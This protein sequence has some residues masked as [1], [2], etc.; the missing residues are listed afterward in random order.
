MF[1]TSFSSLR[2]LSSPGGTPSSLI[3]AEQPSC[4]STCLHQL[5][6][7]WRVPSSSIFLWYADIILSVFFLRANNGRQHAVN[8]E[9]YMTYLRHQSRVDS[10]PDGGAST[11]S[12]R[13]SRSS[14][15]H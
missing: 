6:L 15:L 9:K 14:T 5:S 3:S 13:R 7:S 1:R 2:S 8:T 12:G 11:T 10:P 4:S